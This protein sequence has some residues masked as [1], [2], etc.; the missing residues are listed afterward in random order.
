MLMKIS[1]KYKNEKGRK[2]NQRWS[3]FVIGNDTITISDEGDTRIV[4]ELTE[5]N[6][7]KILWRTIANKL[8]R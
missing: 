3:F 2:Q 6:P 1:M 4:I 8:R 7:F 5:F